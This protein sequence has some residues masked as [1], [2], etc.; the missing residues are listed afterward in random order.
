MGISSIKNKAMTNPE[1]THPESGIAEQLKHRE[2]E[3]LSPL[4][5]R[6]D[7]GLRRRDEELQGYR[8]N[9]AR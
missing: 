5:A 6:S 1:D 8:Q 3:H 9:H 4:A 2:Q 7:T